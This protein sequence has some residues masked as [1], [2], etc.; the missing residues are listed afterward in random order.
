[1]KLES[2][3]IG[4]DGPDRIVVRLDFDRRPTRLFQVALIPRVGRFREVGFI[5]DGPTAVTGRRFSGNRTKGPQDRCPGC[6]EEQFAAGR[7]YTLQAIFCPRRRERRASGAH[8]G[9]GPTA[10]VAKGNCT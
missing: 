9:A 8:R 3:R 2:Q 1:V 4:F 6:W 5:V 7:T 10:R